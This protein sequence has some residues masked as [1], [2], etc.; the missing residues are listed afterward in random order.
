[1]ADR[2][3][4]R[5]GTAETGSLANHTPDNLVADGGGVGV[6]DLHDGDGDEEAGGAR[7]RI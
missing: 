6:T 3:T 2:N 4:C 1:L 7:N 5:P